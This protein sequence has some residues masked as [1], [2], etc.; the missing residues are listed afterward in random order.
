MLPDHLDNSSEG[1]QVQKD[2]SLHALIN[3]HVNM[4]K[5][6]RNLFLDQASFHGGIQPKELVSAPLWTVD[7]VVIR[8]E[9]RKW[10]MSYKL[11]IENLKGRNIG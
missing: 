10:W 6:D 3:F 8:S 2:W 5:S 9:G 4:M 7:K 1:P 11:K